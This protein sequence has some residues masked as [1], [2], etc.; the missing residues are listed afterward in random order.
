MLEGYWEKGSQIY[1]GNAL[2]VMGQMEAESVDLVATD[3]P[4]YRFKEEWWDCQWETVEE[5]LG[6]M[7]KLCDEW[8]RVLRPNGSLYVFASPQMAGR[9]AEVVRERFTVLNEIVWVKGDGNGHGLH[10]KARKEDLRS[11]FP[12]TERVIFAEQRGAERWASGEAACQG[13]CEEL[14]AGVFEPLRLYLVGEKE[15]AGVTSGEIDECLGNYMSGHY[16]GVSQWVLPTRENYERMQALF[17]R[18]G[19]VGGRH[20]RRDY[21]DLRREY[22][23]LR[24]PFNGAGVRQCTDVWMFETVQ[25][26]NGKHVAEKPVALMEHI[27]EMSSRPGDVVLDCCMGSG[28]TLVAA[29]NLGRVGIGI[30]MQ[31]MWCERAMG[32]LAQMSLGLGG[33]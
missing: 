25:G 30:E 9:V 11:Y 21:E 22:E 10:T 32:R 20:L 33:V 26:R 15:A 23:D 5:Y 29:R 16:F 7:G 2:E 3:P 1:L 8:R 4:Y 13:Q 17:N 27:I 6:W 28:T 12:R 24:R 18:G 14:R 19:G 31:A